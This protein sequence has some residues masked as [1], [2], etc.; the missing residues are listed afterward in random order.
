MTGQGK[1][2]NAGEIQMAV[3]EMSQVMRIAMRLDDAVRPGATKLAAAVDQLPFMASSPEAMTTGAHARVAVQSAHDSALAGLRE[4]QGVP[5][6]ERA[7]AFDRVD[8]GIRQLGRV[9]ENS[10]DGPIPDDLI[11]GAVHQL[12]DTV[13]ALGSPGWY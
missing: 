4:L 11:R 9:L 13:R 5:A 1:F 6:F 10:W 3:A 2:G 8:A 7:N 12:D